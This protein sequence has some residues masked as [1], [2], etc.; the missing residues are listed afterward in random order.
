MNINAPPKRIGIMGGTF[1]PLHYGHLVAAEMAR[2]EFA[3]EKVIFIPTGNPPHKVGRRVTSPGDRYEMVKRAVQD[4]SFFEVSDLEIQRKGYSYT[5]D[6]L[7]ELH[8]LYPQHEL[9]FIT[10]AD[11]FR[12]IFTWREVQSVLSLSHFIG[13]SRPGF[14]PLEFLEELKRDYPEFLPNM[15]L[16]DVPALAISSTDIRSRVKEGKPIRYLLPE[17][18]RLYIEKTGLYRI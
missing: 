6:T 7:K 8:E 10:G 12:E 17:S 9:Y 1:D 4:N 16:F 5:V 13:A 3:L 11:A 14:D 15:H 2:H 18:V